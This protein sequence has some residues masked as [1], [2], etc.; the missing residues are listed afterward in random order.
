[1]SSNEK[2]FKAPVILFH[3]KIEKIQRFQRFTNI[4]IYTLN[5]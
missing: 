2:E 3:S 1:M 4:R 5:T